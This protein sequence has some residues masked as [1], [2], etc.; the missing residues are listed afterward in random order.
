MIQTII[1]DDI[2]LNDFYYDIYNNYNAIINK[3]IE[4]ILD[5]KNYLTEKIN[6]N[7]DDFSKIEKNS[8]FLAY[9]AYIKYL[10]LL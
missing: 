5:Q 8:V 3:Q 6:Q 7:F 2:I 9:L 1:T 10:F 4:E